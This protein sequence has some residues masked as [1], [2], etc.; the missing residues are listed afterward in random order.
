MLTKAQYEQ[1]LQHFN[2]DETAIP[3]M[4]NHYFDTPDQRLKKHFSGLRIRI[5]G[6]QIECTIKERN[7]EHSHLETTDPL[8][9][10]QAQAMLAGGP[11][12]APN[13]LQ[14]LQLLR[15]EPSELAVFGSLN[16]KRVELSYEGGLLVLDHSYYLNHEDY[17]VEYEVTDEISG[18]AAFQ[19]FL[20][21]HNIPVNLADKKIARFAQ[22]LQQ[23][24]QTK[25]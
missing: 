3:M 20:Q 2:I 24:Q 14:R 8:T 5:E 23:Y 10:Q 16:T 17:E 4:E 25:E 13:V 6:E 22:A 1:L 11:F 18:I 7:G 15:I 9:L 21:Q 12:T 19:S